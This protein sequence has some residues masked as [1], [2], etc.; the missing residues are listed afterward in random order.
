MLEA[1]GQP[2]LCLSAT[3]DSLLGPWKAPELNWG[4]NP[5]VG[6]TDGRR[7][8]AACRDTNQEAAVFLPNLD[9]PKWVEKRPLDVRSVDCGCGGTRK[10]GSHAGGSSSSGGA[11][12]PCV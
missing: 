3:L 5:G 4:S 10:K 8:E 2:L 6:K 1:L 7:R 11:T 12:L 9:Q